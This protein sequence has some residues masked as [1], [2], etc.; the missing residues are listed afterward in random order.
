MPDHS[1]ARWMRR[2]VLASCTPLDFLTGLES[3]L[4]SSVELLLPL[5]P[6]LSWDQDMEYSCQSMTNK[7]LLVVAKKKDKRELCL[8]SRSRETKHLRLM[9]STCTRLENLSRGSSPTETLSQLLIF[10]RWWWAPSSTLSVYAWWTPWAWTLSSICS[11]NSL[12][13]TPLLVSSTQSFQE[14]LLE[15]YPTLPRDSWSSTTK[16]T[17]CLT[18]KLCAMDSW[19]ESWLSLLDLEACSPTG[20]YYLESLLLLSTSLAWFCSEALP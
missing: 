1:L 18:S 2:E 6:R 8:C 14:V 3:Y 9:S 17:T 5:W 13:T 20:Q 4:F 16:E 12:A 11:L 15:F 7:K 10:P 19:L